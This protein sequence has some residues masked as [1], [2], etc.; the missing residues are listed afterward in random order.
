MSSIQKWLVTLPPEG[1][2]RQVGEEFIHFLSLELGDENI[3]VFD[4]LTYQN[5]YRELLKNPDEDL[6]VDLLNQSLT[7]KSFDFRVTHLLVLALCPITLFTLKLHQKQGVKTL[8]W[9]YED[10]RLA[11]YWKSVLPG[12]HAFLAVQRGEIE[13]ECQR[14]GAQYHFMPTGVTPHKNL[15]TGAE[16]L[17]GVDVA[18]VGIPSPYRIS[19]LESLVANG[20][21]VKIAG[22]GWD[23]YQG[24]LDDFIIKKKWVNVVE[25]R[26]ILTAAKIGL[27]LSFK[28]PWFEKEHTQI[29][30]RVY[31]IL[32][33]NCL[34]VTE[35]VPLLKE[36]L[37]G[38]TYLTF[39]S[40]K[41]VV[42]VITKALEE[43]TD[44][45]GS[46]SKNKQ[47]VAQEHS[48]ANRASQII[49]LGQRL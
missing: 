38:F 28:S 25:A 30:P 39:H 16:A 48:Y 41:D 14:I 44:L 11:T 6:V 8:H 46:F 49:A 27:N 23:S 24:S 40:E 15:L 12:Y 2:A 9:F 22:I 42:G 29:S 26:Q 1:A 45:Q 4:C 31:D 36:T 19:V 32:D 3:I 34:L 35:E 43:F 20:L 37:F 5:A 7:V 18:F 21:K 33:S 10:F 47:L 17:R 13:S